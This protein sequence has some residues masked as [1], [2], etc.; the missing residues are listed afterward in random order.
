MNGITSVNPLMLTAFCTC[1]FV[2]PVVAQQA[3]VIRLYTDLAVG[4]YTEA[5]IPLSADRWR[6]EF[7]QHHVLVMTAP[8]FLNALQRGFVAINQINLLIFDECHYAVKEHPYAHILRCMDDCPPGDIPRILGLTASMLNN[9]CKSPVELR[10]S[11]TDLERA[12]RSKAETASDVLMV[13]Q[14]SSKPE[15]LKRECGE[16][17]DTTGLLEELGAILDTA[18]AFIDDCNFNVGPEDKDKDPRLVPRSALQECRL[19]L[20]L[21]GPW[22]CN[23]VA[24]TMVKQLSKIEEIEFFEMNRMF[25]NYAL[26][27]LR[28][29]LTIFASKFDTVESLEDFLE[30]MSPKV[31]EMLEILHEHKPDD[32]F[33]IIGGEDYMYGAEAS[34][35]DLSD[36]EE[37]E[38]N[39]YNN[40]SKSGKP[41]K[42]QVHYVAV[43]RTGEANGVPAN[44]VKEE[45]SLCGI[46]FVERR[47][48]A[49]SLNKLLQELCNWDTDLYFIQ[50]HHLTGH[51]VGKG[52]TK[53]GGKGDSSE[54]A[55][56]KQED[57]LRKFR[58][59]ELNLLVATSVLEEGV[60]VP[61]CNM[62]IRFDLPNDYRSYVQSKV[63]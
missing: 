2:A 35:S 6:Q 39:Y 29:L 24:Q 42:P 41:Q 58:T 23:R 9:K 52:G 4:E 13:D 48:T 10:R 18:I 43:K 33:E 20:L 44:E 19:M 60:D 32:N 56:K 46:I 54:G 5:V 8:V 3:Q 59:K 47:H 34:D 37:D 11:I 45:E 50:S 12:L 25:I 49:F 31:R 21:L 1:F 14:Y 40:N 51:G 7:R 61:K 15:E 63:S 38:Q 57:I 16:Y 36:S 26:T 55:Y 22:C 27:Q 62:V 30:Y 53:G 17:C 28:L